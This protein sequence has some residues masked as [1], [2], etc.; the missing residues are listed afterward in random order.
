MNPENRYENYLKNPDFIQK[1]IFPGGH[2]PTL[3]L[4]QDVVTQ[5]NF[6]WINNYPITSHYVPT[7]RAWDVAFS[8]SKETIKN[9][10]FNQRFFNTWRYYFNYCSAGF[11]TDF[12][13]NHQFLIQKMHFLTFFIHSFSFV[14]LFK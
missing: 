8:Q 10:G 1:Y 6:K 3:E 4:I 13:Q 9:L 2:L 12:I 11:K 14:C 5:N 7:L